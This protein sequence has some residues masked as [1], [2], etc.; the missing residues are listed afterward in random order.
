MLTLFILLYADDTT[1]MAENERDMQ[2]DLDLLN[3]YCISNKLKV[4]ISKTIL[5]VVA[6]SN[7]R[8]PNIRTFKCGNADLDP[9]KEYIY[10]SICFNWYKSFIKAKRLLHDKAIY[11]LIQKDRRLNLPP[12]VML[13]LF[14]MCVEPILL[15]GCEV[16]GY[17]N[18]DILEKI[19]T[20]FGK[21]IFKYL[22]FPIICQYMER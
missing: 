5:L 18:V 7:K 6:R 17:E 4:N 22:N 15:Y 13:K 20:K 12:D 16:W 1:V 10:L 2:R 9:V 19:H 8:I 11:S 3:E 14:E 21:L